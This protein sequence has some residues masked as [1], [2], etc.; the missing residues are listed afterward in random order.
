[1]INLLINQSDCASRNVK[2]HIST[3]Y[4]HS[5]RLFD[6]V[7]KKHSFVQIIFNCSKNTQM[8]RGRFPLEEIPDF[9]MTFIS[10]RENCAPLKERSC[11]KKRQKANLTSNTATSSSTK[12]KATRQD[13]SLPLSLRSW[14]PPKWKKMPRPLGSGAPGKSSKLGLSI[15]TKE[16]ANGSNWP[17]TNCV[18]QVLSVLHCFCFLDTRTEFN[19]N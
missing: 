15:W 7:W 11:E 1:M 6:F 3:Y 19:G 5:Q 10:L 13:P 14:D 4:K 8:F 17:E 2:V 16:M 12:T 18:A 9:W